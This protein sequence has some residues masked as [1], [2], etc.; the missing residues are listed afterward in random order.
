MKDAC[1]LWK[2][3]RTSCS[4]RKA[5][6][7]CVKRLAKIFEEIFETFGKGLKH[8]PAFRMCSKK[9][10]RRSAKMSEKC[11]KHVQRVGKYLQPLERFEKRLKRLDKCLHRFSNI[12]K[13]F[14]HFSNIARCQES[15]SYLGPSYSQFAFGEVPNSP[16]P[17]NL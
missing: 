9:G 8:G 3:L 16:Q 1:K 14:I 17:D 2:A 10:F 13:R 5:L 6:K 12:F 15:K 7:T 11:L 4:I